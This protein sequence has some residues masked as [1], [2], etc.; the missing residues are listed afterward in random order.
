M[1]S[2]S[3]RAPPILHFDEGVRIM[4]DDNKVSSNSSQ[5]ADNSKISS[6]RNKEKQS[7]REY[8][9]IDRL[10][11]EIIECLNLHEKNNDENND[12]FSFLCKI[13]LQFPDELLIDSH[14]VSWLLQ[15]Q[16]S[17]NLILLSSS[18]SSSSSLPR[19]QKN[20][21]VFV[22]G[23]TTYAPCCV[24][25]VSAKHLNADIII[26]YGSDACLTQTSGNIP[27]LYSFGFYHE[28]GE[29]GE[30]KISN[31]NNNNVLCEFVW[32]ALNDEEKRNNKLL[33]L[34]N[35]KYHSMID[36]IA[37]SLYDTKQ[38]QEVIGKIILQKDTND[39]IVGQIPDTTT[40]TS[41][42][43]NS[44]KN[45]TSVE[46][47]SN[48]QQSSCCKGSSSSSCQRQSLTPN[49]NIIVTHHQKHH[50]VTIGG[51]QV[52]FPES[53]EE[54]DE[55]IML[56]IGENC[57]QMVS[58]MMHSHHSTITT[59]TTTSQPQPQPLPPIT[60]RWAY[61]PQNKSF[62]QDASSFCSRELKRRFFLI[63][64]AKM[65]QIYGIVLG[66]TSMGDT[67]TSYISHIK[68]LIERNGKY[69]Y[70]FIIG[71]LN[72]NKL[73]NFG[74]IETFVLLSCPNQ[75]L[76]LRREDDFHLPLITPLEL[77]IALGEREWGGFYTTDFTQLV[78]RSNNETENEIEHDNDN[79]KSNDDDVD[80]DAPFFSMISGRYEE[81]KVLPSQQQERLLMKGDQQ[82]E[83]GDN[84]LQNLPGKGQLTEYH[85]ASATLYLEKREYQGLTSQIGTT[86]VEKAVEG[87]KGIASDYGSR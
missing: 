87:R 2:S 23:D 30:T 7:I 6:I 75:S 35:V 84:L 54:K 49:D 60:Q 26:H 56:Y 71:K 21:F 42:T 28:E 20:V 69:C 25:E 3:S 32:K 10:S 19:K 31:N 15:T 41:H 37:T 43:Q 68:N 63:E 34:Y 86:K 11:N 24:D 50:S 65:S 55:Y 83:K 64:K 18:S 74:E 53:K 59:T 22:L 66:S 62:T 79:D 16:I 46:K 57:K 73:A 17:N 1:S 78:S 12:D 52:L 72:V 67:M 4:T 29:K 81:R 85:S 8:Y 40:T 5:H 27:V 9:E 45:C 80:D 44:K 14:E 47:A 33:I 82:Q 58:T 36:S 51:L 70:I 77:E 76:F 13:A 48:E 38:Q 39:I 61:S